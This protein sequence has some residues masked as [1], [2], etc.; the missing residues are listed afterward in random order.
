VSADHILI[1]AVLE[2]LAEHAWKSTARRDDITIEFATST[3]DEATVCC[4]VRDNGIGFDPAYADKLFQRLPT[5]GEFPGTGTGLVTV[6]RII[7]RRGGRTWAPGAVDGGATFCCTLGAKDTPS[8]TA[9]SRLP[10]MTP[11]PAG[12][13]GIRKARPDSRP[14][15]GRVPAGHV[16]AARSSRGARSRLR[17]RCRP[18]GR[19]R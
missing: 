9:S 2:H 13:P 4:Y 16:F 18:R 5:A 15:A 17:V 14:R 6:Q 1:R 3:D 7:E 12:E 10:R 8:R 19:D 11:G